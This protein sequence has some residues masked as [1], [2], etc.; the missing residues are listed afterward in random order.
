M[1]RIAGLALVAVLMALV[2]AYPARAAVPDPPATPTAV[3]SGGSA[4]SVDP[5]ATQAAI[6]TLRAGGNAVD[7]TVAA[8]GV[9][10]VVEPFSS[11]IGGGG[12]MVV[13]DARHHRVDTIDSRE[14]A[15]QGMTDTSFRPSGTD[16]P[17]EEARVG[18]LSVGVPGTL[19]AWQTAVQRYG[20]RSLRSLLRPGER[21][22]RRGFRIDKTFNQQVSD[23][24]A[25]FDDFTATR[26][27][28]L[29]P[30]K[31]A[32]PVGDVQRNP[33]LAATYEKIA[34]DPG[35]FYHGAIARD[36]SQT[37]QHPPLAPDS[38]RPHPVHPGT[39]T[40][41]DLA[42]YEA[43]LRKP[44]KIN[45]RGLDVYGMG[46]PSSGGS[47]IG[48]ALNILEGFPRNEPREAKLHHYL[49]ASKLAYADRNEYLGD[50]DVV[51]V[52]LH[53]LLSDGFA[54]ERRSLIT[55]TAL[56]TP[57]DPGDPWKYEHGGH[58]GG[59]FKVSSGAEGPSTTH[60]TVADRWGNVVTYT[61]T[62][63]QIGGS[64]IVVPGR[65]FLLNNELT[66]FNFGPGTANS[67]GPGKR[68]RSSMAPTLVFDHG[69]PAVALGSPGGA[70]I[71]TT[72]LQIL[73]NRLDF[74]QSLPDALAAPRA[75]QRNSEPTPA[76]PA[77]IAQDGP[78]L[79]AFGHT[80]SVVTPN[81]PAEIG[82]ATGIEF[83]RGGRQQ[84]VAEP[85][86][87]GGGSA[88]VVRPG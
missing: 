15:P 44:T 82:A 10:G 12:F 4:A 79:E 52:P 13:Y 88:M 65:G 23:N 5:L 30:A 20:T 54:A 39:M 45:Y 69:R 16:L 76:E 56:P 38:N 72:V 11:G 74:G 70:T 51:D 27:L 47:T 80:F 62:I 63:E 8:A 67:P 14:T 17:F 87:R 71:I 83:L 42:A 59:H 32:K 9:L 2:A 48:E 21:I 35:R 37:V 49:E 22:A 18:G 73:V 6:D 77:F 50:S 7:A 34:A 29:T 57:Q 68:P 58:H 1:S 28:Y 25:I 78:S 19:R 46:P 24:A 36:I 53:G 55:D 84:S 60:L 66:D 3:G 33:D 75:S 61:F 40:P 64:G 26:D 43:K 85:T 31:T 86:R 81:P 41:R